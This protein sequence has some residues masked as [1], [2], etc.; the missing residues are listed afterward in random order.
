MI[1]LM[2]RWSGTRSKDR[3]HEKNTISRKSDEEKKAL[4]IPRHK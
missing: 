2:V 4:G 3:E 1:K